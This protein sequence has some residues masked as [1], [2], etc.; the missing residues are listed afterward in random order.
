MDTTKVDVGTTWQEVVIAT[1][2]F[3]L[4]NIDA[5]IVE[6]AL[7]DAQVAPL[8]TDKGVVLEKNDIAEFTSETRYLY[9]KASRPNTYI[10]TW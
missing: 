2:P 7:M 9:V 6:V 3:R 8:E 4:Q 5:S 1:D 10:I